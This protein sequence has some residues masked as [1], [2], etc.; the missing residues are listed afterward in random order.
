MCPDRDSRS[1]FISLH[2][3]VDFTRALGSIDV[4]QNTGVA[5]DFTDA[6]D[7]IH[8]A[9]FVVGMHDADQDRVFAQRCRDHLGRNQ[10]LLIRVQV[11]DLKP[12]PLQLAASIQHR[13]VLDF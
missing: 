10:P 13:L 6:G 8:R 12:F 4:E 2:V 11:S 3:N 9:D 5:G 1:T 7:I